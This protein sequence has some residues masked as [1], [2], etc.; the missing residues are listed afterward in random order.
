MAM[1]KTHA[2]ALTVAA[3]LLS[4][5]PLWA[6]PRARLSESLQKH[7]A[8]KSAAQVDVIVHGTADEI[9]A[10]AARRRLTIKKRLADGA[11][12]QASAADIESLS[13]EV[14]HL[15]R[16]VE[17]TSFM[18]VTNVAIGADQAWAGVAGRPG[19]TG[20]GV[21]IALIDS[22]VWTGHRALAGRV[23]FAKDFVGDGADALSNKDTFGHGTHIAGI[24]AGD[25]SYPQ[26]SAHQMPFRESLC[27][28]RR[29]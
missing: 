18:S 7:V 1:Q 6:Q 4:S 21:G 10:L 24:I 26:D 15:S 8:S 5:A 16:D 12:L 2:L 17:V 27:I 11:V 14:D 13:A 23:V 19:V 28:C 9:D 29:Q 3:T 22:G 25:S 20:R